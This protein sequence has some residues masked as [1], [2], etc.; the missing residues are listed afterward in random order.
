MPILANSK[1][2]IFIGVDKPDF[3]SRVIE[4]IGLKL[5]K[6]PIS[7]GFLGQFCQFVFET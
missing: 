5:K 4:K 3:L 1:N 6:F 2:V 7:Q